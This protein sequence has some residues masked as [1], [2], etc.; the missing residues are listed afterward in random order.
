M[1]IRDHKPTDWVSGGLRCIWDHD[2]WPCSTVRIRREVIKATVADLIKEIGSD[3]PEPACCDTHYER[4][5]ARQDAIEEIK[6]WGRK[7]IEKID[8]GKI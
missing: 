7:E 2:P 5:Q 8:S 1:S 4:W 3:R 6:E